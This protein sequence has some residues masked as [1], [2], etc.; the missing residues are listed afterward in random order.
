MPK[1]IIYRV[2]GIA[3]QEYCVLFRKST[4]LLMLF[5]LVYF[6]ERIVF[7][8]AQFC[9]SYGWTAYPAEGYIRI[10][11]D[12]GQAFIIPLMFTALL[13]DFPSNQ[14]SGYFSIL[15][16][17]RICWMFGQF[18][19]AL[20]LGLTYLGI[21]LFG[22]AVFLL[23]YAQWSSWGSFNTQATAMQP[24]LYEERRELFLETATIT[25]GTPMQVLLLTTL[26]ALCYLVV[27]IL[28]LMICRL[29][30][31]R[32]LGLLAATL[33][34][35]V[36]FSATVIHAPFMW[37]LPV[38]HAIFGVHYDKFLAAPLC[39]LWVSGLYFFCLIAIL[40]WIAVYAVK[41][42]RLGDDHL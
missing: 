5:S 6:L 29:Y 19:F 4:S 33:L 38:A 42:C 14:T 27:L 12:P 15:R 21:L 28:I 1:Q 40:L 26:L 37:I 24:E 22:T 16:T 9:Q 34:T 8:I 11:S 35:I 7:P 36:G 30:G 32:M 10:L 18:L 13:A 2:W 39:P 41:R 20:L 25:H 23:P 3:S 31:G 17:G